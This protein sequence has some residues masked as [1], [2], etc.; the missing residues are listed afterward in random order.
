VLIDAN[1]E[2]ANAGINKELDT[3]EILLAAKVGRTAITLK[4]YVDFRLAQGTDMGVIRADLMTDLAEGG[5]IFGEFRNALQ[6]TFAGSLNRFRDVGSLIEIGIE[7]DYRWIAILV[8]TCPDCLDRHGRTHTWA[9]WEKEGL[10]RTGA[11]VCKENCKCAL[12][13]AEATVLE[14]IYRG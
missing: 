3:L 7:K 13:P 8:N 11:T 12:I 1:K 10:P 6:P 5:R 2:Y 4:E 14:P 9:E